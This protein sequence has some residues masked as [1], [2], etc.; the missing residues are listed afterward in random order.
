MDVPRHTRPILCLTRRAAVRRLAILGVGVAAAGCTPLRVVLHAYAKEFDA[1]A[2]LVDAVLRAFVLTVIPGVA[3]DDPNLVRAYYD[4]TYPLAKYRSFLAA[5]LC[6]RSAR[7]FGTKRFDGLAVEQRTTVVEEALAG[8]GT[9][10][11]LYGGAIFLA[12]VAIYAGIYD[13]ERGA[14]LIGFEGRYRFR[15]VAAT[16]YPVPERFLAREITL[17]GNPV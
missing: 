1:D 2:E 12:Q 6:R 17:D 3:A 4:T 15:G 5:D 7:R 8:D 9:S 11:K 13:D 16:T 14:P 10:E